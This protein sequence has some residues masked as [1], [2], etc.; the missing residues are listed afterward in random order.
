MRTPARPRPPVQRAWAGMTLRSIARD[1]SRYPSAL[2]A[3]MS[4][5]RAW[6]SI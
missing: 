4:R 2:Y 1:K 6:T 5:K 3:H